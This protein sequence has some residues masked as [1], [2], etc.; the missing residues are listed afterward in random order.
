VPDVVLDPG[1]GFGKTTA[2]NR[3]LLRA[4][5]DAGGLGAPLLVGAS[6]KRS[7]G[8]VTGEPEPARRDPAS[9]AAHLYAAARGAALVRVHD[10]AGHVQA[11][12]VWGWL[13]G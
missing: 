1:I 5:A 9:M 3:A 13:D 4:T 2:H 7:L 6:R 12:R 11:L 10:V 8:E